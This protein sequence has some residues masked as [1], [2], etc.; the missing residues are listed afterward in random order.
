MASRTS[1]RWQ[2]LEVTYLSLSSRNTRGQIVPHALFDNGQHWQVR[3]Y[4]R[5]NGRFSHFVITRL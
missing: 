2:I 1:Y 3:A 5:N 4:E